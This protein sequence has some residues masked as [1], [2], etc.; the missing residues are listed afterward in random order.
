[1]SYLRWT[2]SK[3][4]VGENHISAPDHGFRKAASR[5]LSTISRLVWLVYGAHWDNV[6][7]PKYVGN[8][9]NDVNACFLSALQAHVKSIREA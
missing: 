2:A 6:G 4:C 9:A 8:A 7:L 3:H 5:E 1:M